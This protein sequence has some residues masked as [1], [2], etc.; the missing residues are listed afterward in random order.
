MKVAKL[1]PKVGM[2]ATNLGSIAPVERMR[3]SRR[4]KRNYRL[5]ADEPMCRQCKTRVAMEI[6]H[7]RP[8]SEGGTEDESNL[9]PLCVECHSIKSADEASRR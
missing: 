1:K 5:L 3:G 8:L 9:Q 4:Q 7:I 6:D 2:L